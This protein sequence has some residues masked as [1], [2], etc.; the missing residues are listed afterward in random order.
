METRDGPSRRGRTRDQ[1][2]CKG[3]EQK[4]NRARVLDSYGKEGVEIQGG[5][6]PGAV[7]TNSNPPEANGE[8]SRALGAPISHG[9]RDEDSDEMMPPDSNRIEP[10][11][12]EANEESME[13]DWC[14]LDDWKELPG[15]ADYDLLIV[16]HGSR[17]CHRPL[18][19]NK[20]YLSTSVTR[21][22][23]EMGLGG[24]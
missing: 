4:E 10:D 8:A 18:N 23:R 16:Q 13:I 21:I 17:K 20:S 12:Q 19:V 14:V 2:E 3:E 22:A 15:D 7:V 1:D 6:P 5:G 24:G 9:R 11:S